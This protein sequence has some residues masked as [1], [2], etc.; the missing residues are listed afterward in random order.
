GSTR[1]RVARSVRCLT[2]DHRGVRVRTLMTIDRSDT[3][4]WRRIARVRSIE[5]SAIQNAPPTPS[6][7][8]PGPATGS[9]LTPLAPTFVSARG[10]QTTHP[11]TPAPAATAP[12]TRNPSERC[13]LE[14]ASLFASTPSFVRHVVGSH[15]LS[16]VDRWDAA[17]IPKYV[18][19]P[20]ATTPAP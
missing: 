4:S 17:L 1:R 15:N 5:R 11:T 19:I 12:P 2:G 3:V 8:F 18:P 14:I 7:T 20:I 10:P 9:T 6:P 13:A 16:A